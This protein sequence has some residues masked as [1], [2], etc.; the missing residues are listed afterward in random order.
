MTVG[1]RVSNLRAYRVYGDDYGVWGV[2]STR[3]RSCTIGLVFK[4]HLPLTVWDRKLLTF[5]LA[6]WGKKKNKKLWI[7]NRSCLA[8]RID[9]NWRGYFRFP[10]PASTLSTLATRPCHQ[11]R[12]LA[13]FHRKFSYLRRKP[14]ANF[15]KIQLF[16]FESLPST[17]K[18]LWRRGGGWGG[19][20]VKSAEGFSNLTGM[21]IYVYSTR[22]L[23][24]E[25]HE[26]LLEMINNFLFRFLMI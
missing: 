17:Q 12:L 23:L 18:Y 10:R 20:N 2:Q 16:R 15:N 4:T 8:G 14:Y 19:E 22:T 5:L 3:M 9:E 7:T 24:S 6:I 25:Y 1:S 21:S 13:N 11:G 26:R